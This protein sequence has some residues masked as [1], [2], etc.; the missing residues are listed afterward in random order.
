[1]FYML[2]IYIYI[3][4]EDMLGCGWRGQTSAFSVQWLG[5]SPAWSPKISQAAK[6]VKGFNTFVLPQMRPE[7]LF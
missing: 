5:V 1:M 3:R 4:S 2:Y 6:H 7:P